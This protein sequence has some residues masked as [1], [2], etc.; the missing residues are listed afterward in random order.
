MNIALIRDHE[1]VLGVVHV[2]VTGLT[3]GGARGIGAFKLPDAG[4]RQRISVRVP[5]VSPLRV[6]GSR[7]HPA[8]G[9]AAFLAK[10]GPHEIM[11]MGSSLK[12][13]LV[14]EGGADVYPRLGPTSEWDTAAAQAV[15]ECAG[16]RVLVADGQPLSYNCK[17]SVL[18]PHFLVVG[19]LGHQWPTFG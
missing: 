6:V 1:P 8:P 14:A 3:Y 17:D 10:L 16:G 7:S 18:N 11:P 4:D 9:L 13:C 2:P 5:A 12:F 15:V 19:D